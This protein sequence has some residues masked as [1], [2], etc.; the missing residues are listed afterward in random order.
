L[1]QY[2]MRMKQAIDEF[3]AVLGDTAAFEVFE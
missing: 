3:M 1:E 2:N